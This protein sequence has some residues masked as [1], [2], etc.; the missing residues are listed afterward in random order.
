MRV[1]FFA[2]N[3]SYWTYPGSLTTPPCSESVTW[4]VFKDPIEVSET[5]VCSRTDISIHYI[6][7]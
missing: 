6:T 4:I 1:K 5:Q 7:L 3:P 2:E